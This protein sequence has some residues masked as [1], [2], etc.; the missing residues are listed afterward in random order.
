MTEEPFTK[1]RVP[2]GAY[3]CDQVVQGINLQRVRAH[4]IV[5]DGSVTVLAGASVACELAP[6][7]L[8]ESPG[9]AARRD[10]VAF[11]VSATLKDDIV[12][13][14]MTEATKLVLGRNVGWK[15]AAEL[16][17]D[18]DGR[19]LGEVTD[20]DDG[21]DVP[22]E[23]RI[24]IVRRISPDLERPVRE[25]LLSVDEDFVPPI[26]ARTSAQQ[27]H[28][29]HRYHPSANV[30]PYLNS[31]RHQ[32]AVLAM[33]DDV[34]AGMLSWEERQWGVAYVSTV[35]VRCALRG[36]GIATAMYDTFEESTRCQVAR[37]RTWSGDWSH[38]KLLRSRGYV[39]TG[40]SDDGHG[41]GT[42]SVYL[43]KTLQAQSQAFIAS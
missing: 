40:R 3:S 39:E 7:V 28:F 36:H 22:D 21:D 34:V 10:H 30:D 43:E 16:W 17:H 9:L 42:G 11:D 20:A 29:K 13:N 35:A 38:L 1:A 32:R 8:H 12:L 23:L 14:S 26:S 31:I 25:F 37:I 2:D 18:P 4:A 15:A 33:R 27:T 24:V 6:H 5:R 41:Y 19:T